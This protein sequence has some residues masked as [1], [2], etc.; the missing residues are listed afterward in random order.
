MGVLGLRTDGRRSAAGR[1]SLVLFGALFGAPFG[2]VACGN[3]EPEHGG[4]NAEAISEPAARGGAASDPR[5][6]E[7]LDA[8]ANPPRYE[9]DT[10]WVVPLLVEKLVNGEG[11]PMRRAQEEL[12]EGG[13]DAAKEV[14]RFVE[15]HF[16]DGFRSSLLENAMGAAAGSESR[17]AREAILLAWEH[18]HE[19]VRRAA[20]LALLR[21]RVRPDDYDELRLRLDVPETF[22]IRHQLLLGMFAGNPG[23]AARE[24][25]GWLEEGQNAEL[26]QTAGP[27]MPSVEDP[28]TLARLATLG[29]R[30]LD[31]T[32]DQLRCQLAAATAGAG[33]PEARAWIEEQVQGTNGQVQLW[34]VDPLGAAGLLDP[35]AE[36]AESEDELVRRKALSVWLGL[37]ERDE[38]R[39]G[40][41]LQRALDDASLQVRSLALEALIERGDEG[42][43]DRAL[44]LLHQE[45]EVLV[46]AMRALRTRL[47]SDPELAA[48][49]LEVLLE[50]NHREEHRPLEERLATF[51]GIGLV[52][53][54]DAAAFLRDLGLRHEGV[55][56]QGLRA[57][58]WAMIQAGN[59]GAPGRS[60]LLEVLDAE[61][62]AARR[63]DLIVA[64]AGERDELARSAL[65]ELAMLD[66][67]PFESLFLASRLVLLGPAS[68]MASK[69]KRLS[70]TL[71]D[72][73]ARRA[74][75]CLLWRWY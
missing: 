44:A 34:L 28:E 50:R 69:L 14:L 36:L 64:I 24:V 31:G 49:T 68:R 62:D 71:D 33:S 53:S 17:H 11:I 55:L 70:V 2:L 72:G 13:D 74:V 22:S 37:E 54:R 7:L 61:Q 40:E 8:C 9:K 48:R 67:R 18:P 57:H 65:A 41:R 27:L 73:E 19:A 1:A 58:E 66:E 29:Q 39:L 35:L 6:R 42:A 75:R 45:D 38:E 16:A 20:L 47:Q 63:L 26:W 59:T 46:G 5:V 10:A 15:R 60:Y 23:R 43:I 52:P 56:L 25:L 30:L 32:A 51:K 4:A 3:Q 12:R 21:G